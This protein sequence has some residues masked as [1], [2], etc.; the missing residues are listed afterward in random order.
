M[1][2][3]IEDITAQSAL[4]FLQDMA[5]APWEQTGI[6]KEQ[7]AS[8]INEIEE[9]AKKHDN[10][11]EPKKLLTGGTPGT[12]AGKGWPGSHAGKTGTDTG[13]H[14]PGGSAAFGTRTAANVVELKLP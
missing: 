10:D 6:T 11:P 12:A 3:E 4:Q 9:A 1:E 5:N 8:Q 7:Y 13:P 2:N 14:T